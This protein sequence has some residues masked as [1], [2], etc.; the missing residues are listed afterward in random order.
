MYDMK[1]QY[2]HI[3]KLYKK[4]QFKIRFLTS[5]NNNKHKNEKIDRNMKMIYIKKYIDYT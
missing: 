4:Y 1:I 3:S 5:K 2:L